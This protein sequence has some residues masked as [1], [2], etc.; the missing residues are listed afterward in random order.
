MEGNALGPNDLPD[1]L[2]QDFG[3]H[4]APVIA[5]VF[6]DAASFNIQFHCH[7]RRRILDQVLKNCH[8]VPVTSYGQIFG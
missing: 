7:G 2:F 4:L 5:D 3:Y 6:N 1:W 8:L